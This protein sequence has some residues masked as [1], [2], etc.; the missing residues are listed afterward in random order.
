[1]RRPLNYLTAAMLVVFLIASC[2][3]T[4]R[5]AVN[6]KAKT[7]QGT[8]EEIAK[9]ITKKIKNVEFQAFQA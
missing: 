4:L 6:F 8:P 2:A 1:M 7:F 5:T 3:P 9:E